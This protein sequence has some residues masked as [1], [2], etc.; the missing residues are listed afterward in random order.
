MR[1][2]SAWFLTFALIAAETTAALAAPPP[3]EVTV[4]GKRQEKPCSEHD[5][6]CIV[7]VAQELW[8]HY[9]EQIQKFCAD[10][11]LQKEAEQL[12]VE[13][14]PAGA[15]SATVTGANT[16]QIPAALKKVCDY[17]PPGAPIYDRTVSS[18]TPWSNVP[19]ATDL[20]AVYP[21]SAS[22]IADGDAR[23]NCKVE[24][25]G[26]LSHCTVSQERP[27]G[28]G[29]GAA[30]LKL[31]GKFIAVADAG[32]PRPTE[33]WI[34][35]AVHFTNPST[36]AGSSPSEPIQ[37]GQPD[38]TALPDASKT[39]QLYPAAARDAGV[40][41]GAGKVDC[42]IGDDGDLNSCTLLSEEPVGLGF[43]DAA[44]SA[45]PDMYANLWSRDGLRTPGAH[46]V[47][48][49]RFNAPQPGS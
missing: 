41:T 12:L 5:N 34:D 10:S 9:P 40:V 3:A 45:A 13:D 38:W 26:R 25:K 23:I 32:H 44:L 8:A 7:T 31:S 29:F 14:I 19:S 30:A 24:T 21:R 20:A 36:P 35:I 27:D 42:R 28:K 1:R 39:A 4:V 2:S 49:L 22:T 17:K 33:Q 18:W 43:G 6:G 15:L 37:I 11:I 48:P 47:V 16:L 46:V